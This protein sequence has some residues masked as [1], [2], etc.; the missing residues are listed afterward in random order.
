MSKLVKFFVVGLFMLNAD[1]VYA[2]CM[3]RAPNIRVNVANDLGRVVYDHSKSRSDF[4]YAA[5]D[6]AVMSD[7]TAGATLVNLQ[8]EGNT[9]TVVMKDKGGWCVSISNVNMQ[10]FLGDIIV[11]IDKKY[12]VGSC[13]YNAIIAHENKHVSVARTVVDFYVP[14]VRKE[15]ERIVDSMSTVRVSEQAQAR[16][17]QRQFTREVNQR[18]QPMLELIKEQLQ[19]GNSDLDTPENYAKETGM[20]KNW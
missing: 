20:C 2:E 19:K 8:I 6:G 5:P 3:Q 13:E 16:S 17:V 11:L 15:L 4:R 1:G 9:E 12:P 14:Y 7:D 18:I 10:M